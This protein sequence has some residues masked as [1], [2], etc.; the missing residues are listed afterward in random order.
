MGAGGRRLPPRPLREPHPAPQMAPK[1]LRIGLLKRLRIGLRP[2]DDT[3]P[4]SDQINPQAAENAHSDACVCKQYR[5][6]RVA[7]PGYFGF[8]GTR[9]YDTRR[10][11]RPAPSADSSPFSLM[12]VTPCGGMPRPADSPRGTGDRRFRTGHHVGRT[13]CVSGPSPSASPSSSSPPACS[14]R[15]RSRRTPPSRPSG[16]ALQHARSDEP[17]RSRARAHRDRRP[18]RRARALRGH[19][20][21]GYHPRP[22]R[23]SR[24]GRDRC[25]RHTGDRRDHEPDPRRDPAGRRRRHGR[26]GRGAPGT[27]QRRQARGA[28]LG[29]Q[30]AGS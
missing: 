14:L 30:G 24:S 10:P 5:R 19:Q 15:R 26:R 6:S 20:H 18:G 25:R 7:P 28:P 13:L 12:T 17:A 9:I 11:R 3:P 29:R 1:R 2:R 21:P 16:S 22:G 4:P 8:T 23:D 27:P